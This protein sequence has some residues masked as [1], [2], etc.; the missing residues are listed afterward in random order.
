MSSHDSPK[1]QRSVRGAPQLAALLGQ[2]AEGN[3]E[4]FRQFYDQLNGPLFRFIEKKLNDPHRSADIMHD[5]FM[6]VWRNAGRFEGRSA[7]K[8]W[9]FG[10]AHNKAVDFIRRETRIDLPGEMPEIID[11]SPAG[12][13]CVLAAQEAAHVAACLDTLGSAQREVIDLAFYEDMSY[14]DIASALAVPEGTI[15]TRVFHAKQRLLHCLS[16]RLKR[17]GTTT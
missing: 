9:V 14:R 1:A 11:E 5:V 10:I 6:E 4:A 16:A 15:K 2:I 8:S 7:V 17:K 3:K 12:E 13:A